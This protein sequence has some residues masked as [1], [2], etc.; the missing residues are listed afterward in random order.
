LFSSYSARDISLWRFT[1]SLSIHTILCG[2]G[3]SLN[4]SAKSRVSGI[5]VGVNV[6]GREVLSDEVAET[7]RMFY[8]LITV[9]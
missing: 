4:P 2:K 8:G 1:P 3:S 5:K 9:I 6:A 7:W